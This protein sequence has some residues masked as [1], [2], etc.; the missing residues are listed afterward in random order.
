MPITNQVLHSAK[1]NQLKNLRKTEEISFDK[2]IM[3][4]IMG[5]NGCG[6]STI[7]HALACA[8]KP[9]EE[10]K[11]DNYKF[12]SHFF[13]STSDCD[14]SGSGFNLSISYRNGKTI[15]S[16]TN[17]DYAK[18]DRWKPIYARRPERHVEYIGISSCAPRIENESSISIVLFE[19]EEVQEDLKNWVMD[20]A[21]HIFNKIYTD[22]SKKLKTRKQYIG[23][24]SD[25]I[26]YSSL[27]MGAGEQRVFF[28]LERLYLSPKGTLF[29]I[30]EIDLL[31]HTDAL[32]RLLDV[33]Y[34]RAHD[35]SIQ[36]IF[37]SH[38]ESILDYRK[39]RLSIV[40]LYQSKDKTLYFDRTTPD[41]IHRLTG[42]MQRDVSVYVED[43]LSKTIVEKIAGELG[44]RRSL[45]IVLYGAASNSFTIAAA[46]ILQETNT[47]NTLIVL[48]GD[49]YP[50]VE[51]KEKQIKA[52]LT[53]TEI[54]NPEK[55][56]RALE[57]ISQYTLPEG[58]KPENRISALILS[59]AG[60]DAETNEIQEAVR[61]IINPR[62]THDFVDQA[63]EN[64]GY[65]REQGLTKIVDKAS[66]AEGWFEFI[67][68][69]REW[70][71][72][73]APRFRE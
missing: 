50:T 28:L 65:S 20:K 32:R 49:E 25:N 1:F 16:N 3:T 36:V 54:N 64:L 45:K 71:Q 51:E 72:N 46:L 9:S 66:L 7:I 6:K 57:I 37:T 24:R 38:R 60:N 31:L 4:A 55:R 70:M 61:R 34:E 19:R 47:E 52:K 69:V 67:S 53:G 68:S 23:V 30:D 44:I 22:F 14:W 13:L 35:K 27:T 33:I 41:A 43:D 26:E 12:S 48:D 29:L 2:T 21:G 11:R 59:L 58:E 15:H 73:I 5:P 56:A 17:V 63:I 62:D 8:Y 39:D 40:H 42:Q 18:V 10:M